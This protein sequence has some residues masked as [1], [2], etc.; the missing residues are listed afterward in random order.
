[1][2]REVLL[3]EVELDCA[4]QQAGLHWL[5]DRMEREV[6]WYRGMAQ[7]LARKR[8]DGLLVNWQKREVFLLEFTSACDAKP[9]YRLVVRERKT[10]RYAPPLATVL[11]RL[12]ATWKGQ[13][14]CFTAGVRG[15]LHEADWVDCLEALG[16]PPNARACIMK[17]AVTSTVEVCA[18]M[19]A[20]R[21]RCSVNPSA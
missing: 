9:D 14:L 20:S 4:G 16:V 1:M 19:I 11:A 21:A 8:P 17:A 6:W 12:G 10:A 2:L 13:T 7:E 3:R 18:D 15:S 5:V